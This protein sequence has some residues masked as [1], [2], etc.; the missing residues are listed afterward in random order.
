MRLAW[1]SVCALGCAGVTFA[2]AST[3]VGMEGVGFQPMALQADR[4]DPIELARPQMWTQWHGTAGL[5]L[6]YSQ[7]G[8]AAQ[9][10]T[11]ETIPLLENVVGLSSSATF[12]FHERI[13]GSIVAPIFLSVQT[14]DESV[15]SAMGDVQLAAHGVVLTAEQ[16]VGPDLA[17]G[18]MPFVGLPPGDA[19][20]YLGQ[21][22]VSGGLRVTASSRFGSFA[23]T[24]NVGVR[25]TP[26]LSA[27][28]AVDMDALLTGV[29]VSWVREDF[30]ASVEMSKDLYLKA[31][32]LTGKGPAEAIGTVRWMSDRQTQWIAGLGAGL[33]DGVGAPAYRLFV[34]VALG[35]AGQSGALSELEATEVTG[36]DRLPNGVARPVS[37]P[38]WAHPVGQATV[39]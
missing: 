1:F 21:A 34:G 35:Q 10:D 8:L 30:G 7:V 32:T 26:K 29:G 12:A 33:S 36:K 2:H 38:E 16:G 28:H 14:G 15:T 27:E 20:R 31:S 22:G 24:V 25:M 11:G 18:V 23:P 9:T 4:H 5:A 39:D 3:T 6:G 37:A 17:L 19:D 13:Q